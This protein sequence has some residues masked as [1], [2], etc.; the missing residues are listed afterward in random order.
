M[1][2]SLFRRKRRKNANKGYKLFQNE[3][4]VP[5]GCQISNLKRWAN[6]NIPES[7]N[8]KSSQHNS[9]IPWS[10]SRLPL[11]LFK[12]WCQKTQTEIKG[13]IPASS[14]IMQNILLFAC[15]TK[16]WLLS[17][18]VWCAC[19]WLWWQWDDDNDGDEN[20]DDIDDDNEGTWCAPSWWWWW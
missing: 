1:W 18:T 12:S 11:V 6:T 5:V 4:S 13:K 8:V 19:S 9:E 7:M 20:D 16:W 2:F 15:P 14:F 10:I 17:I 3:L